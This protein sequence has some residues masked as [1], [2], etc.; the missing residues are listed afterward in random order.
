[1]L[2]KRKHRDM[3]C[4]YHYRLVITFAFWKIMMFNYFLQNKGRDKDKNGVVTDD[5]S[6]VQTEDN[7]K[8]PLL[9]N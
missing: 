4:E 8:T 9:D 7:E 2:G 3:G 5:Q 1:M 6:T